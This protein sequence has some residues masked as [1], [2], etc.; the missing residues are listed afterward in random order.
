MIKSNAEFQEFIRRKKSVES[1]GILK[2][3]TK[4][5]FYKWLSTENL[6]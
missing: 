1:E 3:G 4:E 6:S 5:E 2:F